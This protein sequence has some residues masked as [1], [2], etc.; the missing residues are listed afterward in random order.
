MP[1]P[2]MVECMGVFVAIGLS[3]A[4]LLWGQQE[5]D[6]TQNPPDTFLPQQAGHQWAEYDIRRFTG[7]WPEAEHPER[8]V[9][10]W[11]LRETGGDVWF[12]TPASVLSASREAIRVYHK[13]EVLGQVQSV[14]E[15]FV[16]PRC[17][18]Y[19]LAA[20]IITVGSPNWRAR[21]WPLM[22][23]IRTSSA[24]IDA[25]LLSRENAAILLAELRKR[26]DVVDYG[27]DELLVPHGQTHTIERRQ[28]RHYARHVRWRPEG[29]PP[30]ELEAGV[31]DDGF[32][33]RL[34]PLLTA[35]CQHI[36]VVVQCHIDQVERFVPVTV[37]LPLSPGNLQRIQ[38]EVPQIV[39]WRLHERFR[40]PADQILLLSCGIVASANQRPS[41]HW[42]WMTAT[43]KNR[44]DALLMLECR[45]IPHS[46][47]LVPSVR[48][49]QGSTDE[50]SRG[51]Y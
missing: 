15:R 48:A 45:A 11:I 14:V 5:Y 33:L 39:S 38:L 16:E 9:V 26:A 17:E 22:Q 29:Y 35:D 20:R 23:S 51:R 3:A 19:A 47:R 8:W 4:G 12:G 42:T 24:G 6:N 7:R 10:D 30:L 50:L 41:S 40:W 31:V 43:A 27:L 36:D 13:P 32:S 2:R 21:A 34:S 44:A 49:A 28:A 37:D 25:W 18:S 1:H 46:E